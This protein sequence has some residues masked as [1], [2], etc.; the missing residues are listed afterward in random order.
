MHLDSIQTLIDRASEAM[1]SYDL[2]RQQELPFW[3]GS[4]Q[5]PEIQKEMQLNS[6]RSCYIIEILLSNSTDRGL[7]LAGQFIEDQVTLA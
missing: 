6:A 7:S 2:V 3:N 4:A 5:Q 1:T